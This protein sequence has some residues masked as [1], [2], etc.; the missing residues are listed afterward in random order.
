MLRS[1]LLR[2][3]AGWQTPV[4]EPRRYRT[5]FFVALLPEGQVT[6]INR[7]RETR[8]APVGGD[9]AIRLA[10][11]TLQSQRLNEL[12]ERQVGEIVGKNM[13]KVKY[14]AAFQPPA[15]PKPAGPPPV[16]R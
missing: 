11:Q 10:Q 8:I 16:T 12:L 7:L 9:D 14:N 3:W 13:S 4:F 2:V 6:R 5:W 1:D 15:Q